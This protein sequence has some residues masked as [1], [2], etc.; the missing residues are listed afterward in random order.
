MERIQAQ[1]SIAFEPYFSN[2]SLYL[3]DDPRI[4]VTFVSI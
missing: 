2:K 3:M 1:D 4:K